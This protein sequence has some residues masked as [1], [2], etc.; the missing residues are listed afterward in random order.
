VVKWFMFLSE[1]GWSSGLCSYLSLGGR[2]VYVLIWSLGGQVV[3]GG[4]VYVLI[5]SLGG[6]VL[7]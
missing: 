7:T 3:Y 5:W 2:V 4:V 6:Q 1:S